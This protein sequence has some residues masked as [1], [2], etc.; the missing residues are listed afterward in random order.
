M[1]SGWEVAWG[2]VRSERWCRE[3]SAGTRR[4]TAEQGRN[5]RVP[6]GANPVC[7]GRCLSSGRTVPSSVGW[8]QPRRRHT[9]FPRFLFNGSDGFRGL[10]DLGLHPLELSE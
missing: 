4:H 5:L 7:L 1:L 2:G 10:L 3:L 6:S 8:P 9:G